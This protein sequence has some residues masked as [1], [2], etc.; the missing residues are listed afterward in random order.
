MGFNDVTPK[1]A[2]SVAL[3][4][5]SPRKKN[6]ASRPAKTVFSLK[7]KMASK[8][9]ASEANETIFKVI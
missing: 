6:N 1:V 2:N 9:A 4:L 7:S 5:N 8:M 3:A